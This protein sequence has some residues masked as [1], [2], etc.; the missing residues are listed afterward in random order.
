MQKVSQKCQEVNGAGVAADLGQL[1]V[2]E[3]IFSLS[4]LL[5]AII[6]RC[7]PHCLLE[8]YGGVKSHFPT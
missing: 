1:G 3:K 2:G 8:I 6:L 7:V 5:A 4:L